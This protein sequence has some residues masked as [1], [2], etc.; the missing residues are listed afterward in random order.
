MPL[1]IKTGLSDQNRPEITAFNSCKTYLAKAQYLE[2][3]PDGIFDWGRQSTLDRDMR[4]DRKPE[5]PLV[6]DF[7]I[8]FKQPFPF[9][10]SPVVVAWIDGISCSSSANYRASI[11]INNIGTTQF[12][13]RIT[14]WADTKLEL[15][16]VSWF[17]YP[18]DSPY[19]VSGK[20]QFVK[21][22][23]HSEVSWAPYVDVKFVEGKFIQ[24]PLIF[25][26][27]SGLDIDNRRNPRFQAQVTNVTGNGFRLAGTAWHDT[28]NYGSSIS[29]IAF[30]KRFF[31]K[32]GI[33]KDLSAKVGG[34][35]SL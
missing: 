33:V 5:D 7:L 21:R 13:L 3:P 25:T 4:L 20:E 19:I 34:N 31:P 18:S 16:N 15:L 14:S 1:S 32:T 26:A 27:I 6:L 29:Y 24:P 8:N 35:Q 28:H 9:G 2:L 23:K 12:T 10:A 22:G 17:A 30:D 11:E